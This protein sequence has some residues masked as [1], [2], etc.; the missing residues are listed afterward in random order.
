[1]N[2]I[3]LTFVL[4]QLQRK[5]ITLFICQMIKQKLKMK[6]RTFYYIALILGLSLLLYF[7]PKEFY[8]STKLV[9]TGIKTQATIVDTV[10]S[11]G[12]G[13]PKRKFPV[14]EYTDQSGSVN[15]YT[16]RSTSIF[17]RFKIG[18]VVNIVYNPNTK[19]VRVASFYGLYFGPIMILFMGG[20]F[21]F[22]GRAG[23][24]GRLE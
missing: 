15:R 21:T 6:E 11:S 20:L 10:R 16:R 3:V 22:V 1:M 8:V 12:T 17:D 13:Y 4:C 14:F 7:A 23:V 2:K 19:V 24:L 5:H 18:D 9:K